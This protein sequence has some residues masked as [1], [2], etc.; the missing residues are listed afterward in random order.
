MKLCF[1]YESC[2]LYL[3][4][5]FEFFYYS[6]TIFGIKSCFVFGFPII[7]LGMT[8]FAIN[9]SFLNFFVCYIGYKCYNFYGKKDFLLKRK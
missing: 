2:I 6:F 4:V 9:N 5:K 8:S 1:P 7:K 3:F